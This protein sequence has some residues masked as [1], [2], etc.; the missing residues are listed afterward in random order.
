M[1]FS[2]LQPNQGNRVFVDRFIDDGESLYGLM[3][4]DQIISLDDMKIKDFDHMISL[5]IQNKGAPVVLEV[6]RKDEKRTLTLDIPAAYPDEKLGIAFKTDT[7]F[8][9]YSLSIINPFAPVQSLVVYV[10]KSLVMVGTL[11]STV[12]FLRRNKEKAA[13]IASGIYFLI[14]VLIG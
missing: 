10:V 6:L 11:I 3:K 1:L 14:F 9:R 5:F 12:V 13:Y 7:P 2:Y 8:L 4:N